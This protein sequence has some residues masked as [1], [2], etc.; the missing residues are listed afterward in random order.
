MK[1]NDPIAHYHAHGP[2]HLDP[3]SLK[4]VTI[5]VRPAGKPNSAKSAP[6]FSLSRPFSPEDNQVKE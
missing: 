3:A 4:P 5:K 2:I 6:E 1:D